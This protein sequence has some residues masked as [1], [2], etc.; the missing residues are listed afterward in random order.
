MTPPPARSGPAT[1]RTSAARRPSTGSRSW[2]ERS[3]LRAWLEYLVETGIEM[4]DALDAEEADL[5]DDELGDEE[6]MSA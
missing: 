2:S 4:L 1:A 5:E 3:R 6:A